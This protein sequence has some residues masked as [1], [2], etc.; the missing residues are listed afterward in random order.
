M[1]TRANVTIVCPDGREFRGVPCVL[2]ACENTDP[3]SWHLF[4]KKLDSQ[5]QAHT[6]TWLG[7]NSA[8][9]V[10]TL[11]DGRTGEGSLEG[12]TRIGG[13]SALQPARVA[14]GETH[15]AGA[16]RPAGPALREAFSLVEI[17]IVIVILSILA[18][19]AVSQFSD[20]A[21]GAAESALAKDLQMVRRQIEVFKAHHA[22]RLPAQGGRDLVAQL[23]GKTDIEGNVLA[24]GDFGPYMRIFPTNPFTSTSTVEVG[25]DAPGG[26]DHAWY[27]HTG[28]GKFSPD[29]NGHSGL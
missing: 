1:A 14:P 17:L 29:D 16:S 2:R 10:V 26:G 3:P 15:R 13:S 25:T 7:D 6:Y 27:F 4:L 12:I 19:L 21:A 23:T 11:S 9:F 18:T 22:G 28:T 5:F 24:N 20:E 8:R